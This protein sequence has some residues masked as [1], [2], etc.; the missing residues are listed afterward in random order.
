MYDRVL[1]QQKYMLN[2]AMWAE[3]FKCWTPYV[4]KLDPTEKALDEP[5]K[6]D[7]DDMTNR[8]ADKGKAPASDTIG[9]TSAPRRPG[10]LRIV[11]VT[12][13]NVNMHRNY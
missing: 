9:H 12:Y 10:A 13:V 8:A 1:I 3:T 7:E 6:A 4:P 2:Y 11:E 5:K